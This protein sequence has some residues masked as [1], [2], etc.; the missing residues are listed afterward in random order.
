MHA[1]AVNIFCYSSEHD[2]VLLTYCF[3][4]KQ[5]LHHYFLSSTSINVLLVYPLPSHYIPFPLLP[6]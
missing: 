2:I 3:V 1:L 5:H 4:L 6:R